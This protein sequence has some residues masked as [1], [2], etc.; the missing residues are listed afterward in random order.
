MLLLDPYL[1]ITQ[2]QYSPIN[3]IKMPGSGWFVYI[4]E[5][6]IDVPRRGGSSGSG[7]YEKEYQRKKRIR[8]KVKLEEGKTFEKEIIL[9]N[10][11]LKVS[12]VRQLDKDI[13]I[14]VYDTTITDSDSKINIVVNTLFDDE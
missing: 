10:V 14:E 1:L 9:D 8:I 13:I 5:D 2:G 3:E 11:N 4:E 7:I 12:N 6:I